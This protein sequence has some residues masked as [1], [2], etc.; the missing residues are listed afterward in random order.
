MGVALIMNWKGLNNTIMG[1]FQRSIPFA[2][3]KISGEIV[4]SDIFFKEPNISYGIRNKYS[5]NES[6]YMCC[7]CSQDLIISTSCNSK[8]HFKHNPGHYKC[9]LST[10]E[11]NNQDL[12]AF[13]RFHHYRES[14]K[15]KELKNKIGELLNVTQGVNV[16]SIA[17][18]TKFISSGVERRKPDV[19]CRYYDKQIVFEIQLSN[20]SHK[21]I[22]GRHNFYKKLGMYLIWILDDFDIHSQDRLEK[23]IKYLSKYENYFKLDG[24]RS[25]LSFLCHYKYPYI[26]ESNK[27][28]SKWESKSITLP[29]LEFDI[30]DYQVY[31]YNYPENLE[32]KY[33]RAKNNDIIQIEHDEKQEYEDGK[34]YINSIFKRIVDNKN[35]HDSSEIY[36]GI[37]KELARLTV[38]QKTVLNS[39]NLDKLID[40]KSP[41]SVRIDNIKNS[42]KSNYLKFIFAT[43]NIIFDINQTNDDGR[44]VLQAILLNDNL[45]FRHSLIL[46][47]FEHGYRLTDSDKELVS[48]L[49]K[50]END[51]WF[52]EICSKLHDKSL[53]HSLIKYERL[54]S[55]LE[56]A[57]YGKI[58]GSKLPNWIAYTNNILQCYGKYWKDYIKP[59]YE[60]TGILKVILISD[61]K[62]TIHKKIQ[63]L[64]NYEY[65]ISEEESKKITLLIDYLYKE[66]RF[67]LYHSRSK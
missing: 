32:L 11:L 41:I 62:S 18:D 58:V 6:Q 44:T 19:Y 67:H 49:E 46:N 7:E 1:K 12:E 26:S 28:H 20:L 36:N 9:V 60:E 13:K 64:A 22:L 21:Y 31:Y 34:E 38:V 65:D 24:D 61:K 17:I 5:T 54:V 16:S 53:M 63:N 27:V 4:G 40:R 56:S 59:I 42:N 15:H 48:T 23:D 66:Q 3:D 25:D 52:Y 2:K 30:N 55:I 50:F 39:K 10:G 37:L 33:I 43:N 35:K 8:V 51:L 47:L 57:F 29:E 14:K 45:H